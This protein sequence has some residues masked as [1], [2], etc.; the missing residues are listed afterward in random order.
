MLF[1]ICCVAKF[2]HLLLVL[3]LCAISV[4]RY[5]AVTRPV[6]YRSIM[7]SKR[8]KMMIAAVWVLSFI[9]C[10]PPLVGWN[11]D[12]SVPIEGKNNNMMQDLLLS[13]QHPV[14]NNEQSEHKLIFI[15]EDLSSSSKSERTVPSTLIH[16]HHSA[17][18]KR[19]TKTNSNTSHNV[20]CNVTKCVIVNERGY[21]IYSALG[22][23]YIPMFLMILFYWRIYLVASRTSRALKRGYKT[24]K[25][26]GGSNEEKLTLR[27]H[28]GYG[29]EETC[30]PLIIEHRNDTTSNT[31]THNT[32]NANLTATSPK[33]R[34]G[35]L[36]QTI[37]ETQ[38]IEQ[39]TSKSQNNKSNE[40]RQ[41][42]ITVYKSRLTATNN[43]Q[44]GG[45]RRMS[46]SNQSTL[47][48]PSSTSPCSSR[49]GSARSA[50]LAMTRYSKRTSKY[51]AKRFH[52]ETK[53]A[54]TVSSNQLYINLT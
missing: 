26:S 40:K 49:E 4:D 46:P 16:A 29:I 31:N 30:N 37:S 41:M 51:Q 52:A 24:T 32:P 43:Q 2:P 20:S 48:L 5:L 25:S 45:N 22:S 44:N 13:S 6:R 11:N 10:F 17:I 54:K 50:K 42:P 18:D 12:N 14:L 47:S 1:M 53:A 23:F 28:R 7:T 8:A 35:I 19:D 39:S 34:T 36:R 33:I 27:I 9:I 38:I 21:V 3:N 15:D